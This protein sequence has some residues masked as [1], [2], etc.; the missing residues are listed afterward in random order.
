MKLKWREKNVSFLE[1]FQG[2]GMNI[3]PPLSLGRGGR[4]EGEG[5][6]LSAL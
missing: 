3:L 1:S 4:E 6:N 5:K 2:G